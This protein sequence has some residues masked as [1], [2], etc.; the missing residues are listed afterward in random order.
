MDMDFLLTQKMR[1]GDEKAVEAFVTKYYGQI[2]RYC[3]L[4]IG[5]Y[6]YAEDA[7]QETF[8]RFF[9]NFSQYRHYGRAANY[10]YVIAGNLCKDFYRKNREIALEELSEEPDSG[11]ETGKVSGNK[12]GVCRSAG[13][14]QGNGRFIFRTGEKAEGDCGD[15]GDWAAPCKVP[16]KEGEGIASE[17]FRRRLNFSGS[18]PGNSRGQA[19]RKAEGFMKFSAGE[20]EGF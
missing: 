12:T 14:N 17:L 4:R 18:E 5:D 13:G 9:R 19:G 3:R 2:L 10:L 7:A 16:D 8:E 1:M 20:A 15:T 6:G 11:A